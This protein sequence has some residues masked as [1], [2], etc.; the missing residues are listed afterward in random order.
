MKTRNID[1]NQSIWNSKKENSS[2][3]KHRHPQAHIYIYIYII[4]IYIYMYIYIH[5]CRDIYT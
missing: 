5:N 1:Y 3:Y 2:I 4:Y